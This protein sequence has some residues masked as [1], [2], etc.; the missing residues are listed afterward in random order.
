[1]MTDIQRKYYPGLLYTDPGFQPD[2]TFML[3][4]NIFINESQLIF[5][6]INEE[7]K[8]LLHLQSFNFF[9][10]NNQSE[11]YSTIHDVLDRED[12]FNLNYKHITVIVYSGY[13]TLIPSEI[14]DADNLSAYHQFN[15][16]TNIQFNHTYD[17]LED[18]G[19]VNV[20]KHPILS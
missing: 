20:Q 11:Y 17:L 2:Q 3:S 18:L 13:N 4:M 1:M 19:I 16:D 15:F 7:H 8:S 6:I 5:S 12:L 14:F 10:F 9:Q